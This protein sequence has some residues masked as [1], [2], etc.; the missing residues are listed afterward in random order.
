MQRKARQGYR[1]A[2]KMQGIARES[3]GEQGRATQGRA[4]QGK[5]NVAQ[6]ECIGRHRIVTQ[7]SVMQCKAREGSF[8]E[9]TWNQ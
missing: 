1:G 8:L 7:W 3:T 6:G 9:E 2:G 5:G 4:T